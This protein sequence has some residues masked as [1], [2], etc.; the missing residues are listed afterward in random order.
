M[1]GHVSLTPDQLGKALRDYVGNGASATP[2][3]KH[4]R[5]Y[6]RN[7][8]IEPAETAPPGE[9]RP[10]NGKS[11]PQEYVYAPGTDPDEEIK[12]AK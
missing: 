6:L 9:R 12:W 1:P 2:S 10:R 11:N 7:A 5:G 4:F 3:F 8:A